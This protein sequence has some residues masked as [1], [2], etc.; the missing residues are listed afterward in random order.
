MLPI[1][2]YMAV[3][4]QYSDTHIPSHHCS[5]RANWL[6]NQHK[7]DSYGIFKT[8]CSGV[9]LI[10]CMHLKS[11]I[12]QKQKQE[13]RAL[14]FSLQ[15]SGPLRLFTNLNFDFHSNIYKQLNHLI[16]TVPRGRPCRRVHSAL[17]KMLELWDDAVTL[18]SP[19]IGW[20]Q[21]EFRGLETDQ[22]VTANGQA[23]AFSDETFSN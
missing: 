23:E 8:C 10:R 9:P 6:Q 21:G 5:W 15:M 2:G 18:W 7:K 1:P 22:L 17:D 19:V 14:V 11:S 3:K 13:D 12:R 4:C 16:P 20:Q